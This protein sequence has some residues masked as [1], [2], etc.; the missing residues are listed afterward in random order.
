MLAAHFLE[1]LPQRA[2][3]STIP[4]CDKAKNLQRS[5]PV[6]VDFCTIYIFTTIL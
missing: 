4:S 5:I 3:H 6:D 1:T 2:L